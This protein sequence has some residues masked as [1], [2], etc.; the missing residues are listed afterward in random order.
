[1]K[2]A[3]RTNSHPATGFARRFLLTRSRGR[4][5]ALLV[6][7]VMAVALAVT[8]MSLAKSQKNSSSDSAKKSDTSTQVSTLSAPV[9]TPAAQGQVVRTQEQKPVNGETTEREPP[10]IIPTVYG[11]TAGVSKP[12]ATVGSRAPIGGPNLP[13]PGPIANFDGL[14]FA[15]F[16]A[17]HPPDTNGDVGPAYYIQTINTSI[18]VYRKSDNVRVAAFTF[19]A[20]MSQGAFGNLC[21][22]N[23]FGDPVVLYDSFEDRWIIS[24]FAFTLDGSGNVINPPGA[25]QCIAASKTG[26][27]VSG[28]W[29]FYS[30]NTTGGLGDYP[31]LG[32]WPDGLYMSVNMFDYAAG[33]SFQNARAYAFNK[34]QMYAG[35]PTVQSVSFDAPSEIGRA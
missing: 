16:G 31:K 10:E 3:L 11:S 34:A 7:V 30:I 18:G 20:F 28:G 2:K 19:N 23:N 29:N 21:D 17:G 12:L 25:F 15:N 32:I 4:L 33:G 13:M 22:S 35:D 26:D 1:M 5:I 9:K 24:D 27:P 14:D 8:T 6:I